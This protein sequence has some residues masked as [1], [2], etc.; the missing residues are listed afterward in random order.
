MGRPA[1]GK[2][3]NGINAEARQS[4]IKAPSPQVQ[5]FLQ[6]EASKRNSKLKPD[7][8]ELYSAGSRTP[9]GNDDRYSDVNTSP[10]SQVSYGSP[11]RKPSLFQTHRRQHVSKCLLRDVPL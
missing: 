5:S 3:G 2:R 9:R 10:D 4:N 7:T 6:R 8:L 1:E 11:Q